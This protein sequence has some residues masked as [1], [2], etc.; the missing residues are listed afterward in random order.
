MCLQ[1]AAAAMETHSAFVNCRDVGQTASC[2]RGASPGVDRTG[3]PESAA[4]AR[5]SMRSRWQSHV[6]PAARH[7]R[8]A[9]AVA[10]VRPPSP[11][12]VPAG[13]S[14]SAPRGS[15]Y[16]SCEHSSFVLI[17]FLDYSR[18]KT[19]RAAEGF[20]FWQGEPLRA[21]WRQ[22][23]RAQHRQSGKGTR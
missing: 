3:R 21:S 12:A 23:K 22:V 4:P 17:Q 1:A 7:G 8:P 16:G 2:N 10:S 5:R 11:A 15:P 9:R 18:F 13:R 14:P 20:S 6:C 19:A